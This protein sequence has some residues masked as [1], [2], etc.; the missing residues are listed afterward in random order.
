VER[1]SQKTDLLKGYD[2]TVIR[3]ET[4]EKELDKSKKHTTLLQSKL[5]GAFTQY[6]NEY[7]RCRQR[8]MS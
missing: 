7:K 6:H 3:A 8:G 4:L 5:D 1:S 2:D